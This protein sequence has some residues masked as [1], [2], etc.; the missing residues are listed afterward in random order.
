MLI[1]ATILKTTTSSSSGSSS[2]SKHRKFKSPNQVLPNIEIGWINFKNEIINKYFKH[3]TTATTA[4]TTPNTATTTTTSNNNDDHI[5]S[6]D[7]DSDF[8]DPIDGLKW[9]LEVRLLFFPY[10]I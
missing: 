10:I 5:Y 3:A 2:S 9:D 8:D 4:T 7:N 1:L 6:S